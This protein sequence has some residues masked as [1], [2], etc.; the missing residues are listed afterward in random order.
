MTTRSLLKRI[1]AIE[2]RLNPKAEPKYETDEAEAVAVFEALLRESGQ[3][4]K[5][6]TEKRY[7]DDGGFMY[8][9]QATQK[10]W[11]GFRAAWTYLRRQQ[12]A[13]A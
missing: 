10:R 12:G 11:Q 1:E 5:R 3:H 2:Q 8:C 13:A 6:A 4:D 7:I 9:W